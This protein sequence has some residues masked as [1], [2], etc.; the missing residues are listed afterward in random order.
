MSMDTVYQILSYIS[1]SWYSN[2]CIY[3]NDLIVI[4]L[5]EVNK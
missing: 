4:D 2:Q 5:V 3:C 1:V